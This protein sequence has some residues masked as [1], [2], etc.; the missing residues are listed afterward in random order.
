MPKRIPNHTIR[1]Q[2]DGQTVTPTIGKPFDFTDA[3]VKQLLALNPESLSKIIALDENAAGAEG[4][5]TFT[6]AQLDEKLLEAQRSDRQALEAQIRQE[7]EAEFNAKN[8]TGTKVV[9]PKKGAEPK[10]GE[11]KNQDDDI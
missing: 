4:E 3:E 1:I 5:P 2:R 6:Q 9:E 8:G 7:I 11:G 10:K